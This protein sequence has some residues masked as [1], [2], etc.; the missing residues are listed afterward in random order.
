MRDGLSA[1]GLQ[2]LEGQGEY[3]A[4]DCLRRL[5]RFGGD[6]RRLI[7]KPLDQIGVVERLGLLKKTAHLLVFEPRAR[8][9]QLRELVAKVPVHAQRFDEFF[10]VFESIGEIRLEFWI[11]EPLDRIVHER[12]ANAIDASG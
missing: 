9:R 6:F 4:L 11:A 1:W 3:F 10:G 8:R 5:V 2:H 7:A 12:V